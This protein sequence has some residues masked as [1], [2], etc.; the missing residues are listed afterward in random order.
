ML[1][2]PSLN[3]ISSREQAIDYVVRKVVATPT[4]GYCVA[5]NYSNLLKE[6]VEGDWLL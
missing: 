1:G 4:L 5:D 3:G 2:H 6:N